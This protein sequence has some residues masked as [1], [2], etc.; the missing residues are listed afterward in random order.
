MAGA[1][2]CMAAENE[3]RGS[4]GIATGTGG[5]GGRATGS[6]G[7]MF[8]GGA[9]G[10]GGGMAVVGDGGTADGG[11]G[12]KDESETRR[13]DSE[14]CSPLRS[15]EGELD[16]CAL[17]LRTGVCRPDV[18]GSRA[19]V[20]CL[21]L[22]EYDRPSPRGWRAGEGD[23]GRGR[24]RGGPQSSSLGPSS[25]GRSFLYLSSRER[26]CEGRLGPDQPEARGR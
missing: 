20:A 24:L 4:E 17:V 5:G 7:A 2:V 6:A 12:G 15:E 13:W 21:T 8:A 9:G 18:L 3:G 23:D 16:A 1:G 10:G 19:G 26:S 25:L 14:A 11:R 22:G